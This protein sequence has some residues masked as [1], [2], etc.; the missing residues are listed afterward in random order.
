MSET[1]EGARRGAGLRDFPSRQEERNFS[2]AIFSQA[3]FLLRPRSSSCLPGARRGRAGA[4]PGTLSDPICFP[5]CR[6]RG[7]TGRCDPYFFGGGARRWVKSHRVGEFWVQMLRKAPKKL[8]SEL[9]TRGCSSLPPPTAWGPI[10]GGFWGMIS[11]L[12]TPGGE[13]ERG[14][15]K[16]EHFGVVLG[17]FSHLLSPSGCSIR[18]GGSPCV[19]L[20][21]LPGWPCPQGMLST[22]SCSSHPSF[23]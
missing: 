15:P 12:C 20:Q 9:K 8:F 13:V 7:S 21:R 4:A 14:R 18:A 23:R 6:V 10:S 19:T 5:F 16:T 3:S 2:P 17:L 22:H 11:L 1:P